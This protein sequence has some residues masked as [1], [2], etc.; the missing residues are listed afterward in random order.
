MSRPIA[1][2][3]WPSVLPLLALLW[4]AAPAAGQGPFYLCPTEAQWQ[5]NPNVAL[6]DD[7]SRGGEL[8]PTSDPTNPANHGWKLAD[9]TGGGALS[10]TGQLV[11]GGA[12]QGPAGLS[13]SIKGTSDGSPD[14]GG[15]DILGHTHDLGLHGL[16][17]IRFRYYLKFDP[18]YVFRSNHKFLSGQSS[19]HGVGI[20]MYGV[21][22]TDINRHRMNP[23]AD[24]ANST[25][26]TE[27]RPQ[28]VQEPDSGKNCGGG[29][30][31][32]GCLTAGLNSTPGYVLPTN[33]WMYVEHRIGLNT[34]GQRNG[35]WDMWSNECGVS[36]VCAGSPTLRAHYTQLGY[37]SS[38]ETINGWFWDVWGNPSDTGT[39]RIAAMVV[40]NDNVGQIGFIGASSG[41]TNTSLTPTTG[42]LAA[43]GTAASLLRG[44][45]LRP[46]STVRG[47]LGPLLAVVL[48]AALLLL[49]HARSRR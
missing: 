33:I 21:G 29:C 2:R 16:T 7:F 37:R 5:N 18:G 20:F 39:L 22:G 34:V 19:P 27:V 48:L 28:P 9:D 15:P 41:V 43:T 46:G 40:A 23:V 10:F 35:T 26:L 12:G 14:G 6:C 42:A 1:G 36:G 38:T 24:N 3:W 44:S 32:T 25:C 49:R 30:G 47:L 31:S 17:T 11:C 4:W 45:I 13:C 8:S